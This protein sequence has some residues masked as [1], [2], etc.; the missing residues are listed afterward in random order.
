[1]AV[2]KTVSNPTPTVGSNVTYT[3]TARNNGPSDAHAVTVTDK[4]PNGLT[5]VSSTP[6]A[7]GYAGATGA[8][9]I[10]TIASGANVTLALVAT[11][12]SSQAIVNQASVTAQTESDPNRSNNTGLVAINAPGLAD[13]QLQ[14][15]VD[16]D[17]PAVSQNVTFTV[18][19]RNEGPT[20][21]TG[22]EVTDNLPSGL[23]FVSATPSQGSYASGTGIWTVGSVASGASATLQVVTT[24]TAGT[25][26]TR[27]V[28]KAQVE[29]DYASDND[30]DSVT[31]NDNTVSDLAMSLVA[32]QEPVPAGTTFTYSIV[33][34]NHGPADATN[35][36]LTDSLPAGLT[37]VSATPTQGSCTGTT[38]V[39]C[40]LGTLPDGLSAYVDLVVTKTVGGNVS[41]TAAV[42]ATEADPY[43][44]NNSNSETSTP[45]EL[46]NFRVE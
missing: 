10:G 11:V 25:G 9:T 28:T 38:N 23:T 7:G 6:S 3:V 27:V 17:T 20:G 8:W 44:P 36:V 2:T 37:F 13:V 29:P 35:V 40:N 46:T 43:M 41:N 26:I 24:V 31:L 39:S 16:D 5:F 4:L 12:D 33:V 14:E 45:A 19:A 42:T 1:M 34:S 18:T 32:S 30:T 21:V 15:T 22:L